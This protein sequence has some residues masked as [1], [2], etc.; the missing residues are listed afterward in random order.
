MAGH[1][2][3]V[4]PFFLLVA[5]LALPARAADVPLTVHGQAL[6]V[7]ATLN[8]RFKG[9]FLV[10]TGASYVVVSKE[11][12]RKAK[13]RDRTGGE[14]VRLMTANGPVE[15]VLGE[16]RK[17]EVGS[18]SARDVAVAVMDADP[19]PGLDGILGLSFLG[20]FTY[21]VDADAGLLRLDR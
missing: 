19:V 11:V 17:V 9:L 10:D 15:A 13:V 2:V 21:T 1:R 4:L 6:L 12:A 16:V 14:K 5:S 7:E 8:N 3:K 20:Q 18:A